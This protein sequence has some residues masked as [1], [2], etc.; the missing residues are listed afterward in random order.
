[1]SEDVLLVEKK[2]R[3]CTLTINR[4]ERRN[5]LTPEIMFR[6]GDLLHEMASNDEVRVVVI[7][8]SGEL[9]F[10]SGMDL[11][12]SRGERDRFRERKEHPI[13]Y[14]TSSVVDYPGPV[15]AMIYGYAVGAGLDLATSCDIRL[16]AAGTRL[17][18][19]PAKLGGIYNAAAIQRFINIVGP[20]HAKELFFHAGMIDADEA[21]RIG[22]VNHV[23]PP[24][25]LVSTTYKLAETIADNAPLSVR[26]TKVIVHKLLACQTLPLQ[27]E[28]EIKALMEVAEKSED[29]REGQR[30]F[31][32]K[33]KPVFKGR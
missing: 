12:T 32:E 14:I 7:R 9:A 25:E 24:A 18:M 22:L 26:G 27:D 1:M 4:P 20:A 5:A 10:S 19:P 17:G 2:E 33:R 31:M 23:V 15:I 6:V 30:A 29:R 11:G 3:L 21:A 16:A 28:L 13:E 8:G